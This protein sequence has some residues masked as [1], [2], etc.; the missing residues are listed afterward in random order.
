MYKKIIILVAILIGFSG[1][2][3]SC[4]TLMEVSFE[5]SD[6]AT[7]KKLEQ[8]YPKKFIKGPLRYLLI[9]SEW[10]EWRKIK[11]TA[12]KY[13]LSQLEAQRM[14]IEYIWAKRDTSV[15]TERNEFR[16]QFYRN[17]LFVERKFQMGWNSDRGEIFLTFGPPEM[18]PVSTFNSISQPRVEVQA[19][20]YSRLGYEDLY[21]TYFPFLVPTDIF[22]VREGFVGKWEL[23]VWTRDS[24]GYDYYFTAWETG[25]YGARF[26]TIIEKLKELI[27]EDYIYYKDLSFEDYLLGRHK[28]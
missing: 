9:R 11:K 16:N 13:N 17:L 7:I 8:E 12:E 6:A 3:N 27:R 4:A 23:A 24:R 21:E 25:S 20:T 1:L 22:F 18:W 15:D 26:L 5:Y 10:K 19:W 14:F 2:F 28:D